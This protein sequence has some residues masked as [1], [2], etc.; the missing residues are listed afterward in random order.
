MFG[1]DNIVLEVAVVDDV[2]LLEVAAL[3]NHEAITIDSQPPSKKLQLK[4][5]MSR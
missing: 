5:A 3:L 2:V 1:K 4:F